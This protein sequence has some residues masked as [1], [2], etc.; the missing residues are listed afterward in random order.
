MLTDRATVVFAAAL[1]FVGVGCSDANSDDDGSGPVVLEN[2]VGADA[3]A[4]TGVDETED[5]DPGA[6]ATDTGPVEVDTGPG[7]D[8][9]GGDDDAGPDCNEDSDGDGLNDCEEAELCTD[10][11]DGDTD[12]DHLSDFEELQNQTDPCSAD[13]DG[14]GATDK[15]ELEFGFDPNNPKS[16]GETLD[17]ER[18]VLSACEDPQSEPVDFYENRAGNWTMA[19]PPAFSNYTD[20]TITNAGTHDA[21]AVYDDPSNEVAGVLLSRKADSTQSSPTDPITNRIPNKVAN[22]VSIDQDL[23]GGEFDTHDRKT[24]AKVDYEASTGSGKSVRRVR[25]QLLFELADFGSADVSGLP[26]SAGAQHTKFRIQVSVIQRETPSGDKQNVLSAAVAPFDKFENVGKVKFRMDDLTNTTNVSEFVDT[27]LTRCEW[28]KPDKEDPK[29]EFYWVLDQSVS[30]RQENNTIRSFATEFET[31]IR[32]TSLDY[33]LGVTNMDLA[34][35]GHLFVPPAWHT[36]PQTFSEEIRKRV[37]DCEETGGWGCD[38]GSREAGLE[39]G[40]RGLRYMLGLSSSAP[41]P[42]E[43]IRTD[44]EIITIMMTDEAAQGN[45]SNP[46]QFYKGRSTVFAITAQGSCAGFP[47]PEGNYESVALATGGGFADLCTGDLTETLRDIVL[48][49][50]GLASQFTLGQTPVS[51]S[52]RV[53]LNGN[54]VPRD[55]QN[56]FDYFPQ[57]NAIA[58]FGDFRPEGKDEGEQGVSDYI[59]VSFETFKDR[60]KESGVQDC[61]PEENGGSPE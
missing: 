1:L 8:T 61:S 7:D 19:L 5:A 39:V 4:D 45:A 31:R 53:Y 52:L 2:D 49:A 43:K 47:Q 48:E 28:D 56:G 42:A 21:A 6:D 36:Q 59:A 58:F 20:L 54:W 30:M 12:G 38:T 11:H 18:W 37:T 26:S 34:N 15:E 22:V 24:A 57:K 3:E 9:D 46:E 14:D 41:T 33:R 10:P 16:D 25:D 17:G 23:K 35:D 13:S 44:S 51:S 55:R 60:C 29:A 27:N 40:I 32:N 50:T